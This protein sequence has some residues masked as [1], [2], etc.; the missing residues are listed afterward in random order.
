MYIT[1]IHRPWRKLRGGICRYKTFWMQIF[2]AKIP[3]FSTSFVF[4]CNKVSLK[5]RVEKLY[6]RL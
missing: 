2:E 1:A 6:H 5:C 3:V 4:P